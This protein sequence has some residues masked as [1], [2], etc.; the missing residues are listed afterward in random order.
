MFGD[1]WNKQE[2]HLNYLPVIKQN[3]ID[4]AIHAIRGQISISS[5]CVCVHAM[6]PN[7]LSPS[8]LQKIR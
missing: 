8:H 1:T 7:K 4:Q 5:K 2:L 6:L 3:F